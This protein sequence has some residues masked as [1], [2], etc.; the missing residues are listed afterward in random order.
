LI[1]TIHDRYYLIVS[2]VVERHLAGAVLLLLIFPFLGAR[3]SNFAV[4]RSDGRD[5]ANEGVI[6]QVNNLNRTAIL[7]DFRWVFDFLHD[8]EN[9]ADET[10]NQ[11]THGKA[12]S[13]RPRVNVPQIVH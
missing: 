4:V 9:E 3:L 12:E 10:H 11:N 8:E 7:S 2:W 13:Q 1:I 6:F 5:G